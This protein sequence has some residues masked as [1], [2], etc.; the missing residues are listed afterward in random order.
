MYVCIYV[1]IYIYIYIYASHSI[2]LPVVSMDRGAW[3]TR[4]HR[5]TKSWTQLKWLCKHACMH[6]HTHI[7]CFIFFVIMV[8]HR[9]LNIV[10]C[11]IQ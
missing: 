5:V 4:V 1:C 10:P 8:Y 6:T 9:I 3:W 2:F 11:A 7:F